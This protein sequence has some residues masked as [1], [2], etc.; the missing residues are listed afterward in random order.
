MTRHTL[1]IV[2]AGR[3][4]SALCN[5][6]YN[7]G[8]K[9]RKVVSK[10]P[11]SARSL[12]ERYSA[13]W[14]LVPDFGN[15]TDILIVAVTD[16]VLQEVLSEIRCPRETIVAHT[17]GSFDLTVFPDHIGKRGVFYPL[18]TFTKGR[19]ISFTNLPFFIE[20]SDRQTQKSLTELA[21]KLGGKVYITDGEKRRQLHLAAVFTCNFTNHM[22]TAGKELATRADM[23]FT[24]MEA[25]I[26]ETIAK[27]LEEGPENSQ[28]GPAIR[29]DQVTIKKHLDLL[30]FSK[31][32]QD[33]YRYIT[34]SIIKYHK[35][36]T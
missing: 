24:V 32:F 14:D 3:V 11:E 34:K 31:E 2:G 20:A 28:T 35:S 18:Q 19:K 7:A 27:A 9:I 30:S 36:G 21:E 33:I 26:K 13:E 4:S 8:F 25:L 17:A 5:G 1:S 23:D 12:A 10:T 22:L 29:N 16:H 6:F 15:G